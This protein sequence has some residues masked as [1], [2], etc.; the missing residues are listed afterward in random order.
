MSRSTTA[1]P[2]NPVA[3]VTPIRVPASASRIT[4]P[5][6]H[7]MA[8]GHGQ[9]GSRPGLGLVSGPPPGGPRVG[10]VGRPGSW[11]SGRQAGQLDEGLVVVDPPSGEVAPGLIAVGPQW[12]L[13]GPEAVV[14][15]VVLLPSDA[16]GVGGIGVDGVGQPEVGGH[17]PQGQPAR[18]EHE[19]RRG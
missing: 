17:T 2:R 5:L 3:P 13:L 16:D 8:A 15:L 18:S 6:Y 14:D 19:L 12:H 7:V 10:T 1:V 9:L 11:G 4:R